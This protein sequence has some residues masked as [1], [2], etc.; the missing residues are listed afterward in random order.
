MLSL[1]STWF[2]VQFTLYRV[3]CFNIERRLQQSAP[4]VTWILIA[5][6]AV[7]SDHYHAEKISL[8]RAAFSV[9]FGMFISNVLWLICKYCLTIVFSSGV[10]ERSR[11]SS[12]N[13]RCRIHRYSEAYIDFWWRNCCKLIFQRTRD[14]LENW[15]EQSLYILFVTVR[16]I[17][18]VEAINSHKWIVVEA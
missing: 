1:L 10:A 9:N 16:R 12:Q 8:E 3:S 14:R 7:I 2:A 13:G 15:W 17:I 18:Y 6:Q 4:F 11:W 5:Q